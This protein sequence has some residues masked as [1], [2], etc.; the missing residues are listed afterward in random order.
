MYVC[1]ALFEQN[2]KPLLSI[3][4]YKTRWYYYSHA[5]NHNQQNK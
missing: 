2:A 3:A 5:V 1:V 4:I